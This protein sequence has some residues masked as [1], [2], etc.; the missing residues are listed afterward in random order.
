MQEN[1]L[2]YKDSSKNAKNITAGTAPTR[3]STGQI[4]Y[5]QSFN[6]TTQIVNDGG[7]VN[8]GSTNMSVEFWVSVSSF[9]T[10]ASLTTPRITMFNRDGTNVWE[11]MSGDI[12]QVSGYSWAA[13]NAASGG[14][15]TG[16]ETNVSYTTGTWTHYV[17]TWNGTAGTI[18]INGVAPS[19]STD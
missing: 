12:T 1:G 2:N 11:A 8:P 13:T 9:L 14:L 7:S 16:V 4:A 15:M 18:Y 10:G 19:Q 3:I 17:G 5:A 6:A